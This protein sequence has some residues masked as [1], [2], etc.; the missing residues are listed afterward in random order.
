[1]DVRAIAERLPPEPDSWKSTAKCL[2]PQPDGHLVV[3]F[4]ESDAVRR[5]D[6]SIIPH[7]IVVQA[8][9]AWSEGAL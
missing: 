3:L 9:H 6:R 4:P 5:P 2:L 8:A 1:M 7:Q